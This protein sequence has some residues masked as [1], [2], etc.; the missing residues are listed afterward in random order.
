MKVFLGRYN[1]TEILSGPEKVAKRIFDAFSEKDSVFITYFFDGREHGFF[2]K[3][4]GKKIIKKDKVFRMGIIRLYLYLLAKKPGYIHIITFERFATVA[5]KIKKLHKTK[6]FYTVNGIVVHE[7]SLNKKISDSLRKRDKEAETK[8]FTLSD[9]LIFLSK[10]SA[11]N[12]GKYYDT[13]EEK[14]A[15]IPNGIDKAF[16]DTGKKRKINREEKLKIVFAGDA[17]K[18][19]KGFAFFQ[20]TMNKLSISP[21]IYIVGNTEGVMFNFGKHVSANIYGKMTTEAFAEFLK[22]KDLFFSSSSYEQFSITAVESMAAGLVPVVTKETG[23]SEYISEGR[24][25]FIV[26][27]GDIGS[28]VSVIESLHSDRDKLSAVSAEAVKMFDLLNWSK[29]TEMYKELYK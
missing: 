3:L 16:N 11:E 15:F 21:E 10:R 14:T 17:W 8:F 2:E 12:A 22:D 19:E 27:H 23:M 20:D 9:K 4:F 13:T 5:Y 7:D 6:I 26:G 29:V 28:A 18:Q 1:E 24:N 25:G